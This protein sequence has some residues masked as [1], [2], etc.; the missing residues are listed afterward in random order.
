M[1]EQDPFVEGSL[2]TVRVRA[3]F[4]ENARLLQLEAKGGPLYD[5]ERAGMKTDSGVLSVVVC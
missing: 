2:D 5:T 1:P 3:D 4:A